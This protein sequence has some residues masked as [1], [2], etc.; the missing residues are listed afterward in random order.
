MCVLMTVRVAGGCH[1][2]ATVVS[3][4]LVMASMSLTWSRIPKAGS[5]HRFVVAAVAWSTCT[6]L[7]APSS[8]CV[9]CALLIWCDVCGR[10]MPC[11]SST[12]GPTTAAPLGDEESEADF[13]TALVMLTEAILRAT[14][15]W[16]QASVDQGYGPT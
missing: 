5:R 2:S 11:D 15:S 14:Q 4:P 16:N 8:Y 1:S 13:Q 3:E 12:R 10:T 7:S 6:F 9:C